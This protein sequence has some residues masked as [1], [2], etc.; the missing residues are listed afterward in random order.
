MPLMYLRNHP[1]F[2]LKLLT[3]Y[4]YL[5]MINI[6]LNIIFKFSNLFE[7]SKQGLNPLHHRVLDALAN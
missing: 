1:C 7:W 5:Y 6:N 2:K 3:N 4:T